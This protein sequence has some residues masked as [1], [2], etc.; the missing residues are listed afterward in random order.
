MQKINEN[1]KIKAVVFDLDH[2]LFDRYETLKLVAHDL[3]TERRGWLS[4]DISEEYAAKIIVE[5]DARCIIGGWTP[6]L[7]FWKENKILKC[8]SD[9]EYIVGSKELFDFIWNYG[10]VNHAVSYP[11]AN[12]MLDKL[13]SSG[14]KTGLLT[15]ASG[16]KGIFR[17]KSKLKLL[18]MQDKFDSILI[19]GE[20]GVHKPCRTVFDI[21]K[22]RLGIPA[23]NMMYVGDN[24]KNDVYG[25]KTAGY[26]PVWIRIREEYGETADCIYSV[27]DVSEIPSLVDR[28]NSGN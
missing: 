11:F 23:E 4:D 21:M 6:V 22:W 8:N 2:T 27:K 26:I 16:E 17:Q 12:P 10:F 20:V 3:Y 28:I 5:A 13:R 15:N 9:G 14:I 19:T 24:P 1:S 18:G 7:D 25:S